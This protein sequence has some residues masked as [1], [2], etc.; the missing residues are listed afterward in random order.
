MKH[1]LIRNS[2]YY[3]CDVNYG[4]IKFQLYYDLFLHDLFWVRFS[5]IFG[6]DDLK[7]RNKIINIKPHAALML[8]RGYYTFKVFKYK[9]YFES[10]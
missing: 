7:I 4:R 10:R 8:C 9:F 2:Y 5:V 6:D 3:G 1:G